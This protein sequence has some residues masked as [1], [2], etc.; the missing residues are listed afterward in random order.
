[1]K[2][3]ELLKEVSNLESSNKT[4]NKNMDIDIDISGIAYDSRKV[5]EGYLFVA[6]KGEKYDGHD[7]ITEAIKK[8]A[9]A[10]VYVE[11]C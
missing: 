9:V 2:L 11:R 6:I 10:V 4:S 3:R 5:K 1:M 7:F 8:G